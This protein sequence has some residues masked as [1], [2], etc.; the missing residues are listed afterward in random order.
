MNF[1]ILSM[2]LAIV[3]VLAVGAV[4]V[5][6]T[7]G[8]KA[9]EKTDRAVVM[10]CNNEDSASLLGR[11]RESTDQILVSDNLSALTAIEYREYMVLIEGVWINTV[12]MDQ[13]VEVLK[14]LI[15]N[16]TPVVVINGNS[17]II[18]KAMGVEPTGPWATS[19]PPA[20]YPCWG[21]CYNPV[22]NTTSSMNLVT[23]DDDLALVTYQSYDWCSEFIDPV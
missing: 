3:L 13:L 1:R 18:D 6:E 7:Y 21:I 8:T 9:P 16:G 15:H 12:Q 5:H 19:E 22:E 23:Q 11:V 14:S 17:D 4:W 2:S 20:I 10:L